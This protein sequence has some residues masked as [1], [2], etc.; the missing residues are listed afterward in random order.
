LERIVSPGHEEAGEAIGR[1]F[2][3]RIGAPVA[4]QD[5]VA[6]LVRNHLVHFQAVTDR[7]IRRLAKRLEPESIENLCLVITADSNGRPPRP[8][9][10]PENVMMLLARAHELQVRHKPS[11]PI[12]MGRHLVELGLAPG[13]DFG[14]ILD[15]A[16]EAQLEGAFAD[17]AGARRWLAQSSRLTAE[18]RGRIKTV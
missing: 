5:R 17:L 2:L 6:P 13:R 9:S 16:Y 12:L 1:A 3:E 11:E 15:A 14:V 4:V 10:E 7:S 8:P 18:A